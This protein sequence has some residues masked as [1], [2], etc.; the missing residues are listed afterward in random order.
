[1]AEVVRHESNTIEVRVA[2]KGGLLVLSEVD[3]PGWRATVDGSDVPV[4]RADYVLRAVCVPAGEHT[5]ELVYDPPLLKIGL[6]ITAV[7]MV[8]LAAAGGWRAAG[9]IRLGRLK[10]R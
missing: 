1:M 4:V 8:V 10:R 6:G 3:Y 9:W 2:G 7:A 5:V